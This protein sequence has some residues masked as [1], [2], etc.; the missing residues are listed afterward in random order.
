MVVVSQSVHEARI[1][2]VGLARQGKLRSGLQSEFG[3]WKPE[4]FRAAKVVPV[5]TWA[6]KAQGI[7][8]CV[9]CA[10]SLEGESVESRGLCSRH[11]DWRI[12]WVHHSWSGAEL[13][14]S[15]A[16]QLERMVR[17]YEAENQTDQEE[18]DE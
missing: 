13:N 7:A 18:E 14:N 17:Q 12:V 3:Y 4:P 8:F 6:L 11:V 15:M 10:K 16:D 1:R 5:S 2:L 9:V